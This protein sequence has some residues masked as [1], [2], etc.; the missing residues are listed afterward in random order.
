ML[1]VTKTAVF[2]NGKKNF[3]TN[4]FFGV[5]P[6]GFSVNLRKLDRSVRKPRIQC[7][8]LNV[9]PRFFVPYFLWRWQSLNIYMCRTPPVISEKPFLQ[10]RHN[11]LR[12][13]CPQAPQWLSHL[14]RHR[15]IWAEQDLTIWP[16]FPTACM[17]QIRLF[18]FSSLIPS[19]KV[20]AGDNNGN[21][22]N[23]ER[24]MQKNT[25]QS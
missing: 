16:L 11:S 21:D 2:E 10:K 14:E 4:I 13:I 1:S 7:F 24:W 22:K 8:F 20:T 19:D 6:Y 3:D 12:G 23:T 9:T 5:F 15:L 18:A 17:E 25:K